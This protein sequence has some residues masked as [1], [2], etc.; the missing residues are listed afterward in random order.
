MAKSIVAIF[1]NILFNQLNGQIQLVADINP[2]AGNADPENII[3]NNE[4][5]FFRADN[6]ANGKEWFIT[7][8]TAAGT[9][10]IKDIFPGVASSALTGKTYSNYLSYNDILLFE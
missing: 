2:G 4:L 3:L 9:Q 5:V 7:D 10:L 6:G 8:G 1:F